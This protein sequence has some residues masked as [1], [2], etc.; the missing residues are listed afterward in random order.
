MV[1]YS[2]EID[3]CD[4]AQHRRVPNDPSAQPGEVIV[5][6]DLVALTS[7]N[8]TYAVHGGAPLHYWDFFPASDPA[9]GIVP[10]WGYGTVIESRADGVPTGLRLF[11]YW[12]SATH[13]TLKPGPARAGGFSEQSPHR[14]A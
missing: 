4:L 6:V 14:Q 1:R 11:G 10:V 8:V 7:N 2:I 3:R 12:P 9:H 13:A 5:R